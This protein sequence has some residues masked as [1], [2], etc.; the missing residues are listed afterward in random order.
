M[1]TYWISFEDQATDA[2]L[3]TFIFDAPGIEID[4]ETG[5]LDE[6]SCVA[7]IVTLHEQGLIPEPGPTRRVQIQ[8]LPS[9]VAIPERYK[10]RL[11]TDHAETT[12]LGGVLISRHGAN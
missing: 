12:P 7:L 9:D 6:E 11:I 5:K 1:R 3:G 2:W 8:M 4:S 10:G